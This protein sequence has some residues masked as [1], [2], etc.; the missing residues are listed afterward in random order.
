MFF[1]L[2]VFKSYKIP[3]FSIGVGNL[4]LGGTGKTPFIS[5]LIQ[6]ITNEHVVV[7]SRG[8]GRKTK[9]Y[10]EVDSE[11]NAKTVGDE[12][13]MLFEKHK[14]KAKFFVSENRKKGILKILDKYPET[15]VILLD[16]AF[17]HRW[18]KPT[19]NILLSTVDKP[20]YTNYVVPFGRMREA[21]IGAKR[22][23]II[24][25]T[26]TNDLKDENVRGFSKGIIKYKNENTSV[27]FTT[28]VFSHPENTFGETLKTG[29]KVKVVSGLANNKSFISQISNECNIVSE[30]L[31]KDHY[32]YSTNDLNLILKN[33]PQAPIVTTEKD[34]IKIK[35]L[36]PIEDLKPIFIQKLEVRFLEDEKLFLSN[37][38]T[39]FKR[40]QE[41]KRF[42]N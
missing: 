29:D 20:F 27:Y 40:F 21:R 17:Q 24:I 39:L 2:G 37:I 15:Q 16:D 41:E 13:F 5:Y 32:D 31:F 3:V 18:V 26:K 34:F 25:G 36:L 10:L 7:L 19:L 22:A 42:F 38:N 33:N 12:I 1:D 23:D 8:Y 28:H 4:S 6:N 35:T 30:H 9:G 11:S 14:N